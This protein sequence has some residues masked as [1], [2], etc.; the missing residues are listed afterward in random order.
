VTEYGVESVPDPQGVSLAR[1]AE[2][3]AIGEYRLW[4]NRAVR[5]YGQY[6]LHDDRETNRYAFQSGLRTN[7]GAAKPSYL[8]FQIPLVVRRRGARVRIWGHVRPGSG[9]REVTVRARKRGR[10]VELRRLRTNALG[11]FG[12]TAPAGG[13]DRWRA[14]STLPEGRVVS[15][16]LVRDYSF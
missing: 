13:A 4:R 7:R 15:G 12:F 2:Y 14:E 16:P 5:S 3:L 6:L 10:L 11:Y 9:V 1:Q 8:S